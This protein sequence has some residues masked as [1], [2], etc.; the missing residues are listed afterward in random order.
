MAK[1]KRQ[2]QRAK[3]RIGVTLQLY[4][5]DD[6]DLINAIASLPDGSRQSTLKTL[7][8]QSY[9][10][11]IPEQSGGI[12]EADYETM[13][14]ELYEAI[15]QELMSELDEKL[16]KP[17]TPPAPPSVQAADQLDSRIATERKNRLKGAEW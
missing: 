2:E 8:R 9:G 14:Q 12:S 6:D 4:V 17:Y 13:R 5:G 11:P 1:K 7:L 10:M 3:Q 15:R 16:S